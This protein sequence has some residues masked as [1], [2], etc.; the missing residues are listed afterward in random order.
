MYGY[1]IIL[2]NIWNFRIYVNNYSVSFSLLPFMREFDFGS[3]HIENSIDPRKYI[4]R[5]LFFPLSK[6][7]LLASY[8]LTT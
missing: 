1:A 5:I 6:K 7:V 2:R 4:V 3:M 8:F